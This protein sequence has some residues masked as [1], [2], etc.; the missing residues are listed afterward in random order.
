MKESALPDT[1]EYAYV[2]RTAYLD[3]AV[4]DDYEQHRFGSAYGR[5]VWRREQ[6]AVS[7][8]VSAVGE[9]RHILDCPSGVG[10]WV[11]MLAELQPELIV[12]ADVSPAMLAA[13][14]KRWQGR[15]PTVEVDALELPFPDASFDLVFSHALTKH[16]PRQLQAVALA[17]FSR[18]SSRYVICSF[19]VEQGLPGFVRR[20]RDFQAEGL[21]QPV[22]PGWLAHAAHR[23]GLRVVRR[24][25]CTTPVGLEQ[26]ILF[27]KV[28]TSG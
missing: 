22:S 23:A 1:T 13:S 19:S 15:W 24:R 6:R 3:E 8:M 5:Y 26:S 28:A 21:S 25:A 2:A 9:A 11:P 7:E 20:L 27:E 14:R 17:E 10:R 16:L 4:V 12:E 18:V